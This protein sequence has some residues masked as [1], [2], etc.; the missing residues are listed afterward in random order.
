[1]IALIVLQALIVLFSILHAIRVFRWR[2]ALRRGINKPFYV[3]PIPGLDP[4]RD[5]HDSQH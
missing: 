5:T 4:P 3:I 1:M 2:N